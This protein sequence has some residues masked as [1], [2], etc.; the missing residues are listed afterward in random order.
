MD[1]ESLKCLKISIIS[2][3]IFKALLC[4]GKVILKKSRSQELF[5][6]I[7][8]LV[9]TFS[10]YSNNDREWG[11]SISCRLVEM[12][13]G[14]ENICH[15]SELYPRTVVSLNCGQTLFYCRLLIIKSRLFYIHLQHLQ[16]V[17]ILCTGIVLIQLFDFMKAVYQ[18]VTK[19]NS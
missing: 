3:R 4:S 15:N 13:I 17:K 6:M 7:T 10:C 14:W 12:M 11:Q 19:P 8:K 9:S 18:Q 5:N 1:L 16:R 2:F